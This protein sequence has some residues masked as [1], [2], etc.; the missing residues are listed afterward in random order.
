MGNQGELSNRQESTTHKG[1]NKNNFYKLVNK[2]IATK[3][4]VCDHC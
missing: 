1:T 3:T 4:N 2:K